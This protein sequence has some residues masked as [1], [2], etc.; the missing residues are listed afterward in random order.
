MFTCERAREEIGEEGTG[1]RF[2]MIIF[3]SSRCLDAFRDTKDRNVDV[4]DS[5]RG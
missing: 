1:N 2:G 4:N 3:F 5:A